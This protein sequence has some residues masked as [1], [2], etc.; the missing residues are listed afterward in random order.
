VRSRFDLAIERAHDGNDS[1]YRA[2]AAAMPR[3]DGGSRA[4]RPLP[5]RTPLRVS[6]RD[7]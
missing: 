1:L 5:W 2:R 4:A 7:T 3:A 6:S